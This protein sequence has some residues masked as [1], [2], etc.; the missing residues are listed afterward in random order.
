MP[1]SRRRIL[2]GAAVIAGHLSM[3]A[4][5]ARTLAEVADADPGPLRPGE[6]LPDPDFSLLR[7]VNPYIIGVR[8]HREGG[9][10]LKLEDAPIPSPLGPKFLIHNYGHGGA[11][12]TLSFGCASVV[13]DHVETL[14]KDMRRTRIRPSVAV[15]GS[16]VI[17][18]TVATELRRKWARLPIT[19]Y[20]KDMDVRKTTSF[21]AGGQFQPS[22]IYE[23]YE[24]ADQRK[25]LA[26]YLRRSRNRIVEILNSPR[27]TH[28]GIALRKNYTLDHENPGF[29]AYTPFDVVPKPRSGALPFHKLNTAG[30]EYRTWLINPTILLP[31]LVA[32][33]KQ[34]AVSFRAKMFVDKQTFGELRENIIVNCT[35]YGAKALLDDDQ[36]IARRGHLVILKKTLAKQFYFFSGG[37]SNRKTMYVFCRQ[38]D[39][40]VGG[41]VQEGNDSETLA[42]EDDA[43][44][45]RI[46]DN[47]QKV[48]DGRPAECNT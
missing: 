17:G 12:I 7:P 25:I 9:V 15:I 48:F 1:F 45:R 21:K 29:D 24:T 46:C 28:Y 2:Q 22:G 31:Q 6:I 16:G 32:D 41:T 37:C 26:D 4:I 20:A 40:V 10:C 5:H 8:P 47:A 35:G 43:I 34:H 14:T 33:L 36:L 44:F 11:G 13:A 23:E 38:N 3:P 39:I 27:W 18:L 19:I 30:R 42:P